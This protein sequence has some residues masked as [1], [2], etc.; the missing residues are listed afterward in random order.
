MHFSTGF[1]DDD[2]TDDFILRCRAKRMRKLK[3]RFGVEFEL[4]LQETSEEE[5][6]QKFRAMKPSLITRSRFM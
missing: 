6:L 4:W 2:L 1:L 3:L 5:L